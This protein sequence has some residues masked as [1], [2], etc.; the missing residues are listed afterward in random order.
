MSIRM[1]ALVWEDKSVTS[2]IERLVLLAL[3]D[4]S[5]DEGQSWPSIP[6]VAERGLVTQRALY[7]VLARLKAA[8]KLTIKSGGGKHK[9]NVYTL[10]LGQGIARVT[11]T[12]DTQNPDPGYTKPCPPGHP[13]HQEPSKNRQEENGAVFPT[14]K[15]V[16]EFAACNGILF[17]SAKSF[18]EYHDGKNLWLNK[19]G[20][21]IKWRQE[22]VYWAGRDRQIAQ[23]RTQEPPRNMI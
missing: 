22:I 21:L 13:N 10:T 16:R 19:Y 9:T 3:A 4:Y 20:R 5:N 14:F 12:G 11:L 6:R 2:P 7:R 15:E 1:M 8:G 23:K 18:F 17:E